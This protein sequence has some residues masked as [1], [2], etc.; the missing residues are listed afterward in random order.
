MENFEKFIKI[1]VFSGKK[2]NK[3]AADQRHFLFKYVVILSVF[4]LLS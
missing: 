1:D 4:Y 2:E 3:K